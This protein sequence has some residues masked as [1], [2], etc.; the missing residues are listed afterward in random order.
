MKLM[1]A[2]REKSST[3]AQRLFRP[4]SPRSAPTSLELMQPIKPSK[5]KD[6]PLLLE[7]QIAQPGKNRAAEEE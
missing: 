6:T 2:I 4:V 1:E 5:K 3:R 7:F